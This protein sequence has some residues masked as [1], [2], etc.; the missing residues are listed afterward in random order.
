MVLSYDRI[1]LTSVIFLAPPWSVP[2]LA[3]S[4]GQ[5]GRAPRRPIFCLFLTRILLCLPRSAWVG[6]K[7]TEWADH[8]VANG[9]NNQIVVDKE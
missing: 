6:G 1:I 7:Q 8:L 9:G 3:C 2:D 4:P 5:C